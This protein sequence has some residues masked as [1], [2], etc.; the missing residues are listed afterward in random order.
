MTW[1]RKITFFEIAIVQDL[2]DKNEENILNENLTWKFK[3]WSN[4]DWKCT[5]LA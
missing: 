3:L 2:I 5:N 4:F 1:F